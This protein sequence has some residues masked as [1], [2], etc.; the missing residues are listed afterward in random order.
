MK[1]N[2]LLKDGYK[3][4]HKDEAKLLLSLILDYNPLE[5]M[6][7]LDE[8]VDNEKVN[9]FKTA[10]IHMKNGLPMQYVLSNAPFYGY[11]FYVNKNVLIPRFDTE[12][13][14]E[15]TL[16]RIKEHFKDDHFDVLD[17]CTGSGCVGITMKLENPN[18]NLTL[19]DISNDALEVAKINI[20]KYN[21]IIQSLQSDIFENITD[22]Y[23]VII[24]NPPYLDKDEEIMDIVRDNEPSL[25]L[26]ANDKGLEFY[27]RILADAKDY[28]KDDYLIALELNSNLSNEILEI[29]NRYFVNDKITI[30]KDLNKLD[31]LLLI[32]KN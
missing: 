25:A 8:E 14:V 21:L 22:K 12:I 16:K 6:L 29:A 3:Y 23:D 19:S 15:Y 10:V 20:N 11:D 5:L 7:H 31:R 26:F 9:R 4:I 27:K 30:I 17:M 13:V 32:E 24:A 28:L 2:E 18:L 1:V